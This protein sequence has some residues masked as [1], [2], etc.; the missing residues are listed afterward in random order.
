M[1]ERLPLTYVQALPKRPHETRTWLRPVGLMRAHDPA[2]DGALPLAGGWM[3]FTGLD[4]IMQSDDAVLVWRTTPDAYHAASAN[5]AMSDAYLGRL[6]NSRYA[7][8]GLSMAS[9]QLMGIVNATP[10]SFSDGGDHFQPADAL[11]AALKMAKEGA[12]ILDV[13]GESTRPGAQPV[14]TQE[15][16]A[17]INPVISA[18][19]ADDHLVSADTCHTEVMIAASKAGAHILNDVSGFRD[20]GAAEAASAAAEANPTQG[21][22]I[23]MH[24]QGAPQTM[25]SNPD[26]G[27]APL[28]IYDYLEGQIERLQ[29]AGVPPTHIAIDPGFGFGKTIQDNLAIIEWM[30]LFHG[31]GVPILVGVSRKSTIAKLADAPDAKSRLPGTVA[32]TLQT[33]QQGAQ[34]HR[35]HDVGPVKQA[36]DVWCA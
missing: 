4:V 19:V 8:S 16:I 33:V 35:V 3:C 9:P 11:K 29:A 24:M 32:L 25:Q 17:R 13:G 31:L 14:P 6:T 21:Y 36:I 18:L 34:M 1:S 20:K 12:A 7:F 15:E 28:D 10:D 26:Y 5:Q 22:A 2:A 30:S 27:F 23:I